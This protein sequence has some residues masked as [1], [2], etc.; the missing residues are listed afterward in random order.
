MFILKIFVD[1]REVRKVKKHEVPQ[2]A[3]YEW[4]YDIGRGKSSMQR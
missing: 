3:M 2:E 4:N 1:Y